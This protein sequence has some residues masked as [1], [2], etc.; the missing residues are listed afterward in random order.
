VDEMSDATSYFLRGVKEFRSA[1][2]LIALG[3]KSEAL[4][5]CRLSFTYLAKT[6]L[7]LSKKSLIGVSNP[8]YLASILH[9]LGY[10]EI[11]KLVSLAEI[12]SSE[13]TDN[14]VRLYVKACQ[15]LL[16]L[17][18]SKDPYLDINKKTYLF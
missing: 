9:D 11:F 4:D 10:E 16:G 15:E 5:R 14:A 7:L 17:I 1:E 8:H 18:R 13:D 2:S 6:Y 3:R 12:V